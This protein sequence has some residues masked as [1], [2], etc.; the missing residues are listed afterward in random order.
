MQTKGS[1]VNYLLF[2]WGMERARGTGC[3][4]GADQNIADQ[5]VNSMFLREVDIFRRPGVGP[6]FGDVVVA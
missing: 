4:I 6:W 1:R 5:P 2:L 3:L